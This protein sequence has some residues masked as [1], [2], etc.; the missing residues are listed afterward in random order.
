ML[1]TLK[2]MRDGKQWTRQATG[3]QHALHAL[4]GNADQPRAI[5]GD[6]GTILL[7]SSSG[8]QTQSAGVQVNLYGVWGT[9]PF[10]L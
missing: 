5:V 6:Q 1:S 2:V 9:G 4:W 7:H 10:Y 8:W 3:L